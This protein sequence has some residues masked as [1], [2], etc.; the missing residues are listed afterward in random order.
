MAQ[1]LRKYHVPV[2]AKKKVFSIFNTTKKLQPKNKITIIFDKF[3]GKFTY[4]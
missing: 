3:F 2:C 1:N 4:E